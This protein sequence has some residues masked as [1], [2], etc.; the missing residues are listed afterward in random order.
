MSEINE[1]KNINGF[2]KKASFLKKI[3]Y[4]LLVFLVFVILFFLVGYREDITIENI[5]YLLKYVDISGSAI[6][7]DDVQTIHFDTMSH[8]V[9]DIFRSELVVLSK[10]ELKT[11]DLSAKEGVSDTHSLAN[12]TLSM[13]KKA[14]AVY[15]LGDKYYAL[16]NSFSKIY[17]ETTDYPV[18]EIV[19]SDS[20]D[21]CIITS[22]D[23]YRSVL[24]VYN[25]DFEN[26][27][28]WY[29]TD[30]YVVC[31][32]VLGKRDTY[33]VAGCVE[34]NESGDFLTSVVILRDGSDK[35][36]A[37][38]EFSGELILD[39]AFFDNGNI[40]ALTDRAMRTLDLSGKVLS[41][42]SF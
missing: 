10:N 25:S 31:A 16:Y 42:V 36:E 34:N 1:E 11:F 23:G 32:D 33:V 18:W 9:T 24:R 21:Y 27:M 20:G 2:E 29:T 38:A 41:T 8:T 5:R 14:F 28:N 39:V 37:K 12:P 3:K 35:I 7:S 4:A 6:G 30:K 40:C 15:D 13:G 22:E 26:K 17:E 19:F